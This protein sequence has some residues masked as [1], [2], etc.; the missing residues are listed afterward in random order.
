MPEWIWPALFSSV[1]G[2]VSV[3]AILIAALKWKLL[4]DF[5]ARGDLDGMGDR[6][7]N[8]EKRSTT[9]EEA[10]RETTRRLDTI[11]TQQRHQWER[12]A[13]G[14]IEPLRQMTKELKAVS[15]WMERQDERHKSLVERLDRENR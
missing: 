9:L 7:A 11:E 5:A 1:V 10:T 6:V 8:V 2:S 12:I 3:G 14:V 15:A 13:E 4:D